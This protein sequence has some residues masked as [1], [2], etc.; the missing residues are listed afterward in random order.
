QFVCDGDASNESRWSS[1]SSSNASATFKYD[2]GF[3][4]LDDAQVVFSEQAPSG[5]L[6]EGR[7]A[8]GS[9]AK[10]GETDTGGQVG[11]Y[12]V[13]LSADQPVDRVRVTMQGQ[14]M[15]A[16]EITLSVVDEIGEASIDGITFGDSTVRGF[17]SGT[18]DYSVAVANLDAIGEVAAVNAKG[19]VDIEQPTADNGYVATV[20]VATSADDPVVSRTYT[21][22][23][24]EPPEGGAGA[25]DPNTEDNTIPL[26]DEIDQSSVVA[27]QY[28]AVAD[29][30]DQ[31]QG[32][33]VPEISPRVDENQGV[34]S[35][36]TSVVAN[37]GDRVYV[38]AD[39]N[40]QK[41]KV[42]VTTDGSDP[43]TSD[44]AWQWDNRYHVPDVGI[45]DGLVIK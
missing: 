9:W 33:A 11:T 3:V 42:M 25:D 43:R 4:T 23:F 35:E 41:F 16:N 29:D 27:E 26:L 2:A 32:L 38:T 18:P 7:T 20:S 14:W 40:L 10:L 15:K 34:N 19:V 13:A 31:R 22:T 45:T 37:A 39:I 8:S 6:V 30:S 17:K 24:T 12:D 5:I 36:S 28:N 21:V 44:T 1:W